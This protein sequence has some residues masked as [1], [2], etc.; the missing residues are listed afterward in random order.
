M[1]FTSTKYEV[2]PKYKEEKQQRERER[3]SNCDLPHFWTDSTES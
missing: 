2:I 3:E 1:R